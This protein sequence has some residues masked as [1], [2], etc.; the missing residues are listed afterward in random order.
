[1]VTVTSEVRAVSPAKIN[2]S[3]GVGPVREDGYHPLATVYQ[4]IGLYDEVVVRPASTTTLTVS[5]GGV[6]VHDVPTD[7]GN[8]AFRAV[9]ALA[10][11]VGEDLQ[12]AVHL[13]KNIP[14]AGGLAGGSTDAAATLVATDALFELGLSRTELLKVAA[15]LGSDVPFCVLG[16]TAVGTGRGELV[17]PVMSR[18]TYW[19]AVVPGR[20]GLPTPAVYAEF[21]RLAGRRR[22]TDADADADAGAGADD[23]VLEVPEALLSAL[24]GND[25]DAVGEGLVNDLEAA[26][27]SLRPELSV[28][29]AAGRQAGAFGC[30][31]S[32]SGPT[33]LYLCADADHAREVRDLVC[34]AIGSSVGFVAP[35]PVAGAK[36]SAARLAEGPR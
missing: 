11:H 5:G 36:V 7:E 14:V 1:V 34:A 4:A 29:L 10:G 35:G 28:P 27:L 19:W 2:L 6:D 15:G 33:T 23:G 3:L 13:H 9:R 16:G 8:L 25:L 21:D 30:L 20:G 31:V 24:L 26:A 17:A 22:P 12:V 32:G 18:G